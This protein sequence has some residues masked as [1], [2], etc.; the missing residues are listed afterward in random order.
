MILRD[1]QDRVYKAH[2]WH[3]KEYLIG[4][5]G[6]KDPSMRVW[7]ENPPMSHQSIYGM[8]RA[9]ACVLHRGF[10]ADK[11]VRPCHAG[12]DGEPTFYGVAHCHSTLDHFYRPE[13]LKLAFYRALQKMVAGET[14]DTA[15]E[16][17]SQLFDAFFARVNK[18]Q[19]KSKR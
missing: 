1:K 8:R 18:P 15:R 5:A 9:T 6:V 2:L 11:N 4:A 19:P 3:M 10:C 13:G 16:L 17:K 12:A 14:R 7:T